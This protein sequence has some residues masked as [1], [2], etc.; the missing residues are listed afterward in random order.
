[1]LGFRIFWISG[2]RAECYILVSVSGLQSFG[3]R[4]S[5]IMLV[6]FD[7]GFFCRIGR[8]ERDWGDWEKV[9]QNRDPN[10]SDLET[11]SGW[12]AQSK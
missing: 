10:P 11:G 6:A 4:V 1:M 2:K 3:S 5:L 7:S 8:E 12:N 9:V